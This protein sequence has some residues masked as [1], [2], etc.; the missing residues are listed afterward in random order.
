MKFNKLLVL[1]VLGCSLVTA[2][3]FAKDVRDLN[4]KTIPNIER[5]IDN[6][7]NK[8][9]TIL[10]V[11]YKKLKYLNLIET[12]NKIELIKLDKNKNIDLQV[13]KSIAL[14]EHK[15]MDYFF[16]VTTTILQDDEL[17]LINNDKTIN[18]KHKDVVATILS[19]IWYLKINNFS[20]ESV[21]EIEKMQD[22]NLDNKNNLLNDLLENLD[23]IKEMSPRRIKEYALMNV[24]FN[25]MLLARQT[26]DETVVKNQDIAI[27]SVLNNFRLEFKQKKLNK[28]LK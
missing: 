8:E 17:S 9:Q 3:S 18:E 19:T 22:K 23:E 6:I 10:D 11:N 20:S 16:D 28:K 1:G 5:A 12:G 15:K 4:W 24:S 27:I 14:E 13:L 25:T 26:I 2:T 7:P 21:L